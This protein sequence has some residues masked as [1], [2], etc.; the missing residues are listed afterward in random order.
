MKKR[1]LKEILFII[2]FL[3]FTVSVVSAKISDVILKQKKAVVT[4]YIN[5]KDGKQVATG[6]GFIIDPN[7]IVATNYHVASKWIEALGN[8]II[9]KMENGAYYPVEDITSLD[10]ENDIALLKVTGKELP[11]IKLAPDYKPKQG[12]RIAVIGSPFGLETT[13]SDGIIS[14]LR[15]K[16]KLIQITAPISSGSSGS[17]VFNSKG[18]VIGVATFLIEGGQNL[19]FAIPIR[20]VANLLSESKKPK[21][22]IEPAL[23]PEAPV[24]QPIKQKSEPVWIEPGISIGTIRLD[25]KIEKIFEILGTPQ[26]I[27]ETLK[28]FAKI[29]YGFLYI[30]TTTVESLIDFLERKS[31]GKSV[32]DFKFKHKIE[33]ITIYDINVKTKGNISIGSTLLDVLNVFGGT[34]YITISQKPFKTI[35]CSKVTIFKTPEHGISGLRKNDF[36][37]YVLE[38]NYFNEGI[39]FY[40]RIDNSIPIVFA[41]SISQKRE[42]EVGYDA[43]KESQ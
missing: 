30:E 1:G 34:N 6:S 12:E 22:K 21:Q 19:N 3:I 26:N 24:S 17:P 10:V 37:G 8:I 40:F 20:H 28:Y 4:I 18:E 15:G 32:A 29:D 38:I 25:E 7:G 36:R 43:Q 41:I 13:V 11:A 14:S 9:L 2:S 16:N 23:L 39:S 42:C 31:A 33:N 27:D 5:D 35:K